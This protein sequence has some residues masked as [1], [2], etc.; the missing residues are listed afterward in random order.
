M[1][2]NFFKAI[3]VQQKKNVNGLTVEKIKDLKAMLSFLTLDAR[4]Y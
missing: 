3:R 4:E 2:L 1:Y